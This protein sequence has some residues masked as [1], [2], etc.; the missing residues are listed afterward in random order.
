MTNDADWPAPT[1]GL[2]DF[3]QPEFFITGAQR[4]DL[5]T[6]LVAIPDHAI[7]VQCQQV[8]FECFEVPFKISEVPVPV[9]KIVDAA[10][11]G[12]ADLLQQFDHLHLVGWFTEPTQMVVQGHG[13]CA[14]LGLGAN[15]A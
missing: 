4:D 13:A 6:H 11:V 3:H 7:E 14:F 9:V 12:M 5:F 15:G 1:G 2:H 10:H 8:R